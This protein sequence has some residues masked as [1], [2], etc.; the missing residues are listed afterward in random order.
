MLLAYNQHGPINDWSV[1]G[2]EGNEEANAAGN[3]FKK[4]KCK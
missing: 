2:I 1:T 4:K 3:D